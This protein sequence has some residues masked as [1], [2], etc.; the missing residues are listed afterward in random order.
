MNKDDRRIRKTKKA[1][2]EGLAELII[3]KDLHKITVRELTDRA[4]VHRAT[5]YSHYKD[6]YDLYEQLENVV[7]DGLSTVIINNKSSSY[8]ELFK[9]IVDYVYDN[10]K[11]YYML[12]NKNGNRNFRDRISDFLEKRYIA[13]WL[14]ETSQNNITEEWHFFTRYHIQGCLAVVSRWAENDYAYPKNKLINVIVRASINF[15]E[16]MME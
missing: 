8:E 4:D 14:E 16:I 6:V 7:V 10:S 11:L 5:F 3:E 9:A 1:L 2:R 15:D 12:L 13:D